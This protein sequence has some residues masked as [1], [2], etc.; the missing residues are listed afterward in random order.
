M[1]DRAP[2]SWSSELGLTDRELEVLEVIV[3]GCRSLSH[4]ARELDP[5]IS[6]RT[7]EAH[8]TNIDGKLPRDFEPSVPPF[9]RVIL[10]VVR[11]SSTGKTE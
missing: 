1:D 10:F 5:P 11:S 4:I 9:W 8:V 2:V 6:R 3:V 7:A